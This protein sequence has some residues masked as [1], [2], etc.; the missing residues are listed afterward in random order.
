MYPSLS[1][2]AADDDHAVELQPYI[3][4]DTDALVADA[5]T[6][7]PGHHPRRLGQ[8]SARADGL[9][10]HAERRSVA[11]SDERDGRHFPVGEEG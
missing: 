9:H 4:D 3:Y 7:R 11:T 8:A 6:V 2:T 10:A 1:I 5:P